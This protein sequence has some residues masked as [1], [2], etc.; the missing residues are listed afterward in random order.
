MTSS[1]ESNAVSVWE[2]TVVIPTYIPPPPDP[3]PMFLEK[4]VNQGASGRVYPN[5]LTDRLSN[6]KVDR[7]YQAVKL[8]NEYL[9]LMV[10]PEI[11]GRIHVGLDKTNNYNFFYRQHVIKPALIGTRGAWISGGVEWNFPHHHRP[12]T[13]LPVDYWIEKN[14]DGSA[15]LWTADTE[16]RHRMRLY[17]AIT[18]HPDKSY[19]E[20][21]I[22]PFNRSPLVH[23]FLYFANP[24]VHVDPTYQ[25]IFPPDVEYVTQHAKRE[26]SEWPISF[27]RYGGQQYNGVDISQWKN[28][29]RPVSFFAWNPNSDYFAGYNHGQEAGVAYVSNHHISPGKKFFALGN[30][31]KNQMW[32]KTHNLTDWTYL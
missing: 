27:S 30:N 24:A 13:L 21:T 1:A 9:R 4:R 12:T 18:L 8:E 25:V 32:Y 31:E 16:R 5:P 14:A 26:F 7:P 11:G 10:L 19:V 23:S 2:E 22:H 17:L 28:L 3:N 29:P 15:T 20:V 6:E